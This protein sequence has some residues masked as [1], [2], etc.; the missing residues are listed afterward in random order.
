MDEVR[1]PRLGVRPRAADRIGAAAVGA[2]NRRPAIDPTIV[3]LAVVGAVLAVAIGITFYIWHD[4]G[5][6]AG[7]PETRAPEASPQVLE[8]EQLLGEL[9]FTPGPI[10]GVL[11]VETAA[12]IRAFQQAA[13]LPDDGLAS[14]E[15]LEE[16]K[17]VAGQSN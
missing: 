17:A 6:E 4:V 2:A 10:D 15:L 13:G 14:P 8:I 5:T 9:S 16:L 12:A 3:N 11:D 1:S 7:A